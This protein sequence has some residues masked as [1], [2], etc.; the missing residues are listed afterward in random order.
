MNRQIIRIAP[1]QAGKVCAV[2]YFALGILVG[3]LIACSSLL[4][5]PVPGQQAVPGIAFAVAVPFLYA[6]AGLIFVPFTCWLYNI[7]AG[8]VGGLSFTVEDDPDS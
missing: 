4:S 5:K 8:L 7:A 2:L 6:L 3:I 1:W